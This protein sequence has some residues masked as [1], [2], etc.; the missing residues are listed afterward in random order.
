MNKEE[1][2][3]SDPHLHEAI[4]NLRGTGTQILDTFYILYW[5]DKT[6]NEN[7]ELQQKVN[8]L[9]EDNKQLLE[10]LGKEVKRNIELSNMSRVELIKMINQLEEDY[11][12][13]VEE[14]LKL[15]ELWQKSQ[16]EKRQLETNRDEAIKYIEE[17]RDYQDI[18]IGRTKWENGKFFTEDILREENIKE[19]LSLLERGKE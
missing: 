14:N 2:N 10:R 4:D 7:K 17:N 13:E 15:S 16:E 5:I 8:Q 9:E 19:L 3:L 11:K 1:F 12:N 6:R 18:L